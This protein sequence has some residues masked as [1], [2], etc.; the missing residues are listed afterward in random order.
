MKTSPSLGVQCECRKPNQ[1]IHV[2]SQRKTEGRG[3]ETM[4]NI[5][6]RTWVLMGFGISLLSVVI[7][8]FVLDSINARIKEADDELSKLT[9]SL[10]YQA[11]EVN[12]A[13]IQRD[14]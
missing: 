12:Q 10:S 4:T 14:L 2:S 1:F 3:R 5:S 7:N 9:A 6:P 11:A 8:I 13:E